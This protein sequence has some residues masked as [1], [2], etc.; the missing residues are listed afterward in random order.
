MALPQAIGR[1]AQLLA[2]NV[3][4]LSVHNWDQIP[5]EASSGRALPL[6]LPHP[7]THPEV[8]GRVERLDGSRAVVQQRP[9]LL[10]RTPIQESDHPQVALRG[11]LVNILRTAHHLQWGGGV[12]QKHAVPA[13]AQGAPRAVRIADEAQRLPLLEQHPRG[14]VIPL[15]HPHREVD[16]EKHVL[17]DQRD[18]HALPLGNLREEVVAHGVGPDRHDEH[19]VRDTQHAHELH[20]RLPEGAD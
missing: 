18:H 15:R 16:R 14:D 1:L 20:G 19:V 17:P 10:L 9:L 12:G 6:V 3:S 11:L 5:E 13:L 4:Q 2:L 7:A 8:D